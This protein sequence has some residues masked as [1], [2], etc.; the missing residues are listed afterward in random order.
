VT[1]AATDPIRDRYED[2]VDELTGIDGVMPP[3]G[4]GGFG[5]GA[6]RYE[7]KIFAML[8]RGRLVLKLP[9]SRVTALIRS[10][11]GIAFDANK[12]TPMREWLS[13]DPDSDLNWLSLATEALD[14]ARGPGPRASSPHLPG[15]A[16]PGRTTTTP[17]QDGQLKQ[18][19]LGR[20]E[21]GS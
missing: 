2:L 12:G 7:G 17:S 10:G 16:Q 19:A 6:L 8:V 5:R 9:A 14:F 11:N 20:T 4:G 21:E 18:L 1:V 15:C 3:R 13:L